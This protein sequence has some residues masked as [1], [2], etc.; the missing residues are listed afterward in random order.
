MAMRL[1]LIILLCMPATAYG[2]IF[3]NMAAQLK[4]EGV[5]SGIGGGMGGG[6][7][8]FDANG[9]GLLDLLITPAIAPPVLYVQQKDGQGFSEAEDAV[10][11]DTPPATAHGHLIL[12]IDN[13]GDSDVLLL[14]E[15]ENVL[16]R[17]DQGTFKD[18]SNQ[19]LPGSG[20]WSVSGAIGDYDGDG[21]DDILIANYISGVS[22]PNHQCARN[23]LLENDGKGYFTDR[24]LEF[25]LTKAGCSLAVTFSDYDNDGDLDMMAI[26]DFGHFVVPNELYRNDGPDENGSWKFTD[27]SDESAFA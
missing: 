1:L 12:D 14:R 10:I 15:N 7:S 5:A 3:K 13:D 2:Q 22:F 27:V 21:D 17:N 16:F 6:V 20:L 26:N 25:G 23:T 9:D 24:A 19:Q 18:V 8:W 11:P 4:V